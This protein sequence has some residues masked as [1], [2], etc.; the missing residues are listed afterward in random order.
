MLHNR[1]A[2]SYRLVAPPIARIAAWLLVLGFALKSAVPMLASAAA[3]LQQRSVAEVCSV[4][5]VAAAVERRAASSHDEAPAR[6]VAA[7]AG[8]ACALS[9]LGAPLPPAAASISPKVVSVGDAP[10]RR[11][12]AAPLHD[13]CARW[14]ARL[15]HAPP[16]A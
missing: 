11:L 9:T 10:L 5:G 15:Q 14:V 12:V 16:A 7:H 4:Y 6:G 13:A 8:D 3:A 2:V 1:G